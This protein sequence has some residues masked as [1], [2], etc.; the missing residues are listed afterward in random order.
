M[1]PAVDGQLAGIAFLCH[2]FGAPGEDLVGLA[3]DL[4]EKR[5]SDLPVRIVFPAGP[6]DLEDSG[7]PGGRAWW[8]IS[9]QELIET[10]EEGRFELIREQVPEG[11]ETAR[12]LLVEAIEAGLQASGLAYKNLLVGGFS[13]GA[14]L[15]MEVACLGLAQPPRAMALLSGALIRE[16]QWK[17]VVHRLQMTRVLQSHGQWDPILPLQLGKWLRDMLKEHGCPVDFLE[18][19]G[20]HTIPLESIEKVSALLDYICD[21]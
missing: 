18:F 4:L 19:P 9:I 16:R 1:E 10:M 5:H 2:G 12:E 14:M 3:S 7:I 17:P 20:P 11:I 6:L 21:A 15:A 13:Q 8:H